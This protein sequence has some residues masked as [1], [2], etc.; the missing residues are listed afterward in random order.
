MD[1]PERVTRLSDAL[2]ETPCRGKI[3]IA[4]HSRLASA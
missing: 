1:N 2:R 4:H 3:V